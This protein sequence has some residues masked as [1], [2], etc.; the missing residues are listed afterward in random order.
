MAKD[1]TLKNNG[2]AKTT[3]KQPVVNQSNAFTQSTAKAA[4]RNGNVQV[5]G[6]PEPSKV[7]NQVVPQRE[8]SGMQRFNYDDRDISTA[9]SGEEGVDSFFFASSDNTI[10]DERLQF[11]QSRS[12]TVP[13]SAIRLELVE[14]NLEEEK[15][16][17]KGC[18]VVC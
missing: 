14:G 13:D 5:A 18:C 11:P 4:T 8:I 7:P 2:A 12:D 3:T 6:R 17:S 1:T 9:T 16:L 15:A 10:D